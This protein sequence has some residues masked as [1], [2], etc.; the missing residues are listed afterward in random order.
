MSLGITIK[1]NKAVGLCFEL[2][3]RLSYYIHLLYGKKFLSHMG[4]NL[5][6]SDWEP[7]TLHL[8]QSAN[9]VHPMLPSSYDA[10]SFLIFGVTK[11]SS[12]SF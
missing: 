3:P 1:T 12:D 8:D 7:F 2:L 4:S 10:P 6:L 11:N 9:S 5:G